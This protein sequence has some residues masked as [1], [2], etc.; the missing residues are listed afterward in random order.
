MKALIYPFKR[1]LCLINDDNPAS[2]ANHGEIVQTYRR[3]ERLGQWALIRAANLMG[4]V[5]LTRHLRVFFRNRA[6]W[7]LVP[8]AYLFIHKHI[9]PLPGDETLAESWI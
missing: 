2:C 5:E 1:L 8:N 9:Y 7:C 3:N 6:A 4:H